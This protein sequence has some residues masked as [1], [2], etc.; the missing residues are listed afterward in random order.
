MISI[1][2]RIPRVRSNSEVVGTPT[3]PSRGPLLRDRDLFFSRFFFPTGRLYAVVLHV[4]CEAQVSW[5][6]LA[7]G[8]ALGL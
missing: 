3:K 1:N 8:V 5:G 7:V 2:T 6:K 4:A